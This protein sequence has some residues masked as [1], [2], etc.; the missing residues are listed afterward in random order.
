MADLT[1][2]AIPKATGAA[3]IDDSTIVD[4]GSGGISITGVPAS[5]GNSGANIAITSGDD[6]AGGDGAGN[7]SINA[8][9]DVGGG[10]GG[11]VNIR[12]GS[13]AAGGGAGNASFGA[14]A[15]ATT[16]VTG[17]RV[18]INGGIATAGD[19]DGGNVILRP[20]V[21]HGAGVAGFIRA[22]GGV[23]SLDTSGSDAGIAIG[24]LPASPTL[25]MM[26]VVNDAL[27]PAVGVQVANM[28][29]AKAAVW[30]NGAQWTVWGI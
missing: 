30:W 24:S 7:V 10:G 5:G 4:G 23:F 9:N 1:T 18:D 8:G 6:D 14:G 26:A 11:A 3:Q 28:G 12:S 21:G 16:G 29:M 19:A 22:T 27:A 15:S 20:G 17:G 13:D 2:N 25:G